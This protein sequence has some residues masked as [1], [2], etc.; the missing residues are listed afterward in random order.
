MLLCTTHVF[1]IYSCYFSDLHD[2]QVCERLKNYQKQKQKESKIA[3][4]RNEKG[5]G[6]SI[7]IKAT[8]K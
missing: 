2:L 3:K 8:L 4:N 1:I 6:F 5:Q 7:F